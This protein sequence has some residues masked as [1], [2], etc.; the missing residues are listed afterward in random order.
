VNRAAS[1][2]GCKLNVTGSLLLGATSVP[3][4]DSAVAIA[5]KYDRT[6]TAVTTLS[7]SS[8][9]AAPASVSLV[10]WKN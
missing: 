2:T 4:L 6:K 1:Q 10:T 8:T 9:K 7:T 5:I 3:T